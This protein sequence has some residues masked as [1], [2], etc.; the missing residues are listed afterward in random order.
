[1]P[2]PYAAQISTGMSAALEFTDH[3]GQHYS[4]TVASTAH[5]LDAV[6][7]TLQVELQID[8]SRGELL[9]GSYVQ[10]TFTMPPSSGTL[11]VPVNTVIFRG[12]SPQVATVDDSH[13]VRLRDITEGRDFGTEIEVL[14]GIGPNDTLVVNPPDSIA[15]GAQVRIQPAQPQQSAAAPAAEHS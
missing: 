3:P 15:D 9:P 14:A 2:Q 8:N 10:V 11:R 6:S 12:K 5:A 1:V 13:H 4:A 7:R